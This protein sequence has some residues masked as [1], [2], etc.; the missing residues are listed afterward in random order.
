MTDGQ[1]TDDRQQCRS[2]VRDHYPSVY[3]FLLHITRDEGLAEDLTQETFAAAWQKFNTF[4]HRSDAG[5]WLCRI[6]YRK[7]ID[8]VR[9]RQTDAKLTENLKSEKR[10]EPETQN[11]MDRLLADER[12]RQLYQAVQTLDENGRALIILHYLQNR[13]F[14]QMAEILDQPVGSI[15]WRV[16]QVLSRLRDLMEERKPL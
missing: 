8:Q 7:F 1:N 12:S 15:K 9:K 6:A 10:S 3:R 4:E 11:P 16:N 13:S 2:I 5:T 14:S